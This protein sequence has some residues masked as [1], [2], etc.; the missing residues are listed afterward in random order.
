MIEGLFIGL[1]SWL[2]SLGAALPFTYLLDNLVGKAFLKAPLVYDF[3][4][5]GVLIWLTIVVV[6][7]VLSC[8]AP[9][10]IA[11]QTSVRVLLAY[12]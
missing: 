8:Y 12:E 6:T 9:A 5:T 1:I 2:I 11:V 4:L 3:S 7:V 10:Q